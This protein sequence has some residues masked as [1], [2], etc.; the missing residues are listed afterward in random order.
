[1]EF[2]ISAMIESIKALLNFDNTHSGKEQ[3]EDAM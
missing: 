3:L 2:L 1:M